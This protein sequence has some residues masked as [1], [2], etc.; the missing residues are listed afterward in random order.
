[1]ALFPRVGKMAAMNIAVNEVFK[2]YENKTPEPFHVESRLPHNCCIYNP[3]KSRAGTFSPRGTTGKPACS[4]V[5]GS[6]LF[7]AKP[8][9]F[10]PTVKLA[11]RGEILNKN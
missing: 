10:L 2:D 11:M 9:K 7:R 1:M 3:P 6:S 8:E 5:P 4:A